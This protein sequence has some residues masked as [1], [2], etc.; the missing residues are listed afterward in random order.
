MTIERERE[1]D[2][3][4]VGH[5]MTLLTILAATTLMLAAAGIHS[6]ISFTL[7]SRTREIGIRTAL[8]AAPLHIVRNILGPSFI[9]IAIGIALGG[10]PGIFLMYDW[11]N[12]GIS[13]PMIAVVG[14]SVACFIIVIAVISSI[15]PVR[16]ALK[17]PPTEALRTT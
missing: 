2:H 4:A 12:W 13:V 6:L 10:T 9:R 7:A 8:G 1:R 16:R 15:W 5:F 17:I 3:A 11:L 14:V